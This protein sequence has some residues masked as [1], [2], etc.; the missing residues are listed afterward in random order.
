M[1][2]QLERIYDA[3]CRFARWLGRAWRL[4]P[5]DCD[6]AVHDALL[7]IMRRGFDAD[8][9]ASLATWARRI[10]RWHLLGAMR[11]DA[12]YTRRSDEWW[13]GQQATATDGISPE[14]ATV[15]DILDAGA[16]REL[17]A[18]FTGLNEY[19]VRRLMR[20]HKAA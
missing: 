2:D 10:I 9:P 16:G 3:L 5:D 6:A 1:K 8:G 7:Y 11:R 15:A 18:R 17:V 13:D 20:R 12:R 4:H 14:T 19:K